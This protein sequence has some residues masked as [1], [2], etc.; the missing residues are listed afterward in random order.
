MFTA[1][2]EHQET[3]ELA[4]YGLVILDLARKHGGQGWLLYD[5]L[6]S[7]QAAAGAM[8]PWTELNSS[9]MAATVLSSQGP[10]SRQG[11]QSCSLCLS[12]DHTKDLCAHFSLLFGAMTFINASTAFINS[13]ITFINACVTFINALI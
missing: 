9:L 8:L 4:A 7:Q 5:G 2:V 6:F 11:G 3:R 12:S 1:K 13:C 10:S